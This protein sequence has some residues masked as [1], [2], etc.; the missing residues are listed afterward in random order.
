[1]TN[2]EDMAQHPPGSFMCG[3]CWTWSTEP[4]GTLTD[5]NKHSWGI[6]K[7]CIK[8]LWDTKQPFNQD[9]PDAT[10]EQLDLD[11]DA[12]VERVIQK[13]RN[14]SRYGKSNDG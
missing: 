13:L 2:A 10:E 1:M 11:E 14:S 6:C 9:D 4:M 12:I 3:A 8:F 5:P 7:E